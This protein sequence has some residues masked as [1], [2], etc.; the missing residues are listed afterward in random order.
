MAVFNERKLKD[1]LGDI[2]K[3]PDKYTKKKKR[4]K[5][6]AVVV[7]GCT[8]CEA[9]VPFCPVDCI[10]HVPR[11]MAPPDQIIPPVHIRYDE[12]IGCQICVRVCDKMAWSV[13]VMRPTAEVEEQFGIDIHDTAPADP[14]SAAAK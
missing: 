4:P 12:C 14:V 1:F 7:D 8:G 2:P 13:I 5:E 11:S 10:E 9:C 6:V 3:I